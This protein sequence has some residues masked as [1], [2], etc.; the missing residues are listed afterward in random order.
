[1]SSRWIFQSQKWRSLQ[2]EAAALGQRHAVT[3]PDDEV[4]QYTDIHQRQ[5]ID[6]AAGELHIR[7]AGFGHAGGTR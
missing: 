1:M 7:A 2:L 6:E 4:I 3:V 5:G